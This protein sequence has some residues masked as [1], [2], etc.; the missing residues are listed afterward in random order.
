MPKTVAMMPPE[1]ASLIGHL[2]NLGSLWVI[3]AISLKGE[4]RGF[5]DFEGLERFARFEPFAA[6]FFLAV[7]FLAV[8]FFADFF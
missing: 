3:L 7:D 6:V 8:F 1:R 4:K 2:M 5:L